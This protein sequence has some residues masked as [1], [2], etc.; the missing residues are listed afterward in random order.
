MYCD[1][2]D[3]LP[4]PIEVEQEF[5]HKAGD[6]LNALAWLSDHGVESAPSDVALIHYAMVWTPEIGRYRFLIY[7]PDHVG[8]K[9]PAEL[10]IRNRQ[11]ADLSATCLLAASM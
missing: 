5:R 1:F 4:L 6:I 9:H 10:A 8:P 11:R 2:D 7:G 3:T